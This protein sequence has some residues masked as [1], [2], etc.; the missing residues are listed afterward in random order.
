MQSKNQEEAQR[1]WSQTFDWLTQRHQV[2]EALQI[3]LFDLRLFMQID[4]SGMK[5][6]HTNKY[7]GFAINKMRLLLV[8]YCR[9]GMKVY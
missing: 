3:Q 6:N 5:W 9:K 7:C 4:V 8:G 2:V 1:G